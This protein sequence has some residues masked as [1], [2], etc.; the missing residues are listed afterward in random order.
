[1]RQLGYR[2]SLTAGTE[3]VAN[4]LSFADDVPV[5]EVR[6]IALAHIAGGGDVNRLRRFRT[7]GHSHDLA[8]EFDPD[9]MDWPGYTLADLNALKPLPYSNDEEPASPRAE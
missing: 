3:A 9:L 8:F 1:L 5:A 2:V 4:A 6:I 7:T